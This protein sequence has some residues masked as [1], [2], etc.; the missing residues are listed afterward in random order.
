VINNV[1]GPNGLLRNNDT[2]V[3]W[4]ANNKSYFHL[5]DKIVLLADGAATYQGD[6]QYSS[7][8]TLQQI[9]TDTA[10][11]N[12]VANGL[13][14]SDTTQAKTSPPRKATPKVPSD[15]P[16]YHRKDGDLSLYKYYILSAGIGNVLLLVLMTATFAFFS[17]MPALY[18]KW[19]T[20]SKLANTVLYAAGYVSMLVVAW[21]ATSLLKW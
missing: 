5:G 14:E 19:W 16:D 4:V 13:T 8:A 7:E 3:L 15:A 6:F 2:T 1:L 12:A 11:S 20:E 18:L 17:T 10:S 9:V 21:M